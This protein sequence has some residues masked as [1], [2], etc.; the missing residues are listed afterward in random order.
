MGVEAGM[1]RQ[2]ASEGYFLDFN[3]D[4]Q[5]G[6]ERSGERV[7]DRSGE[8]VVDHGGDLSSRAPESL[9][10]Q[11]AVLAVPRDIPDPQP[12]KAALPSAPV[13]PLINRHL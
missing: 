1:C 10:G 6:G 3:P 9:P 11:V 12:P 2:F 8:R 4:G 13:P 7:G 5:H